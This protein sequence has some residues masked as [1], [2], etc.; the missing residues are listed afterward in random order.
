[1]YGQ[2][3]YRQLFMSQPLMSVCHYHQI[4]HSLVVSDV[5]CRIFFKDNRLY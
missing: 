2:G 5:L 4:K 1:M 3:K